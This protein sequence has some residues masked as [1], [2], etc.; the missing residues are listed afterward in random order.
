MMTQQ[1]KKILILMA[2]D[3]DDD[4]FLAQTAFEESAAECELLFAKDGSEVLEMLQKAEK[5]EDVA[6]RMPN[7]I[8]L[9]L[10][11]PRKNGWQ[12]LHELKSSEHLKHIPVLIFTTSKS[13]EHVLMSYNLGAS[14]FITKP[15]SF[16]SL[17]DVVRLIGQYWKDVATLT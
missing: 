16:N 4:R 9:D 7:L 6:V 2:D 10:N 5:G 1:N 11:M 14:S 15:S 8:L 12:V 13:P 3:D 17:L